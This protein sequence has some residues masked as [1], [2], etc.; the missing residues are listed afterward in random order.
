MDVSRPELKELGIEGKIMLGISN[1]ICAYKINFYTYRMR[2]KLVH[3][4]YTNWIPLEQVFAVSSEN[5]N[6]PKKN[7]LTGKY[8][9]RNL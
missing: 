2:Q 6:F 8:L 1:K 9:E 7:C 5:T 4:N 3:L